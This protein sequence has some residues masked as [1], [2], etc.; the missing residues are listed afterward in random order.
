MAA[1]TPAPR[2]MDCVII[3]GGPAGLSA[4]LCLARFRRSV[5]VIDGGDSRARL[6]P[7][8]RNLAGFPGGISGSDLLQLLQ[9]QLD[10]YGVII[11]PLSAIGLEKDRPGFRIRTLAGDFRAR[12]VILAT[13]SLDVRPDIA[14]HNE[15]VSEGLLRYCPVCDG[16]EVAGQ[17]VGLIALESH[18]AGKLTFLKSL[19]DDVDLRTV[20]P[21]EVALLERRGSGIAMVGDAARRPPISIQ[22]CWGRS[23]VG[24]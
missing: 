12:T 20:K 21:G 13:G 8:I 7:K 17:R 1:D 22:P 24:R 6:I 3:G 9:C 14:G 11:H 23:L 10:E 18:A 4:A 19:T 15:A 16:Y 5:V 2:D